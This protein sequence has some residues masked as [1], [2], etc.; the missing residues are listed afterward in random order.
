MAVFNK[1]REPLHFGKQEAKQ[2][3]K[4]FRVFFSLFVCVCALCVYYDVFSWKEGKKRNKIK[5]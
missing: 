3:T 5:K 4:L 1:R 2:N